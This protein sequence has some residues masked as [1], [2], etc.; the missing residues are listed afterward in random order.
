M[1]SK[2]RILVVED[3]FLARFALASFLGGQ[4]DM[5]VVG[6]AEGGREAIEL[7]KKVAPDVV[8]M[9]LDLPEMDGFSAI[10]NIIALAP[11]ARILV[12]SNLEGEADIHRAL[13]AGARGYARKDIAGDAL[14]DAIRRVHRGQRFLPPELAAK[15]AERSVQAE[16]TP[17]EL[18]VLA[19]ICKG[20]SNRGIAT[21]L[22]LRE[23]TVRIYVSN[24]LVK[25]G[26]ERR[27]EAIA[28]AM[29]RGLVRDRG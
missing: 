14:I 9:D 18:D 17:R 2:L 22:G 26:V 27:T 12:L 7:F 16:L 1:T 24:I 6:K 3:H 23:S 8:L 19:L 13:R 10:A 25:L 5:E 29:R 15:L 28:V 21:T 20:E 4:A 11:A